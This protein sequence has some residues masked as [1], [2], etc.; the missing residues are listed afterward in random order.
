M[1]GQKV[2]CTYSK[3]LERNSSISDGKPGQNVTPAS[4]I[5]FKP[6]QLTVVYENNRISFNWWGKH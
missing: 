6:M 2:E 1:M 3:L 5:S 4:K